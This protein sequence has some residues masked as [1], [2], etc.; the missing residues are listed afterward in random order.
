MINGIVDAVKELADW[1]KF[2]VAG[3]NM[4]E[5]NHLDNISG[6]REAELFQL[7]QH[8][9]STIII[10]TLLCIIISLLIWSIWAGQELYMLLSHS[11]VT[12]TSLP[13][14][15]ICRLL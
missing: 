12:W 9:I 6:Y 4:C 3:N 7:A 11:V 5:L 1:A 8:R 15:L 10:G 13:I 14:P 2:K